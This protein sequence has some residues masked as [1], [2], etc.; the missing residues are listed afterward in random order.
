MA[1]PRFVLFYQRVLRILLIVSPHPE[2]TGVISA[3]RSSLLLIYSLQI[4]FPLH[5]HSDTDSVLASAPAAHLRP[6][7]GSRGC[8]LGVDNVNNRLKK[9]SPQVSVKQLLLTFSDRKRDRETIIDS[10]EGLG[11]TL[12][13][14]V[15]I[16]LL[17][18]I[19]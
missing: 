14:E 19:Q 13:F 15:I 12:P 10:R 8:N 11:V 1:A 4:E 3:H 6:T 18:E 5:S 17:D 2:S 9:V 16:S 7:V